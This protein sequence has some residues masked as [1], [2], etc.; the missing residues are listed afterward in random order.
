MKYS[1]DIVAEAVEK[2][3]KDNEYLWG[4]SDTKYLV[5]VFYQKYSYEEKWH[6]EAELLVYNCK[7]GIVIFDNDFCEGQ[8]DVKDIKIYDLDDVIEFFKDNYKEDEDNGRE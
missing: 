4:F 1:D 2:Y 8:T 6:H 5:A 3:Y 7:T